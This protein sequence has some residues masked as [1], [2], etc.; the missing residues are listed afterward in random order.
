ML[1]EIL[2]SCLTHALHSNP[3]LVYSLLYQREVFNP[4]ATT[5]VFKDLIQNIKTVSGR[6]VLQWCIN[7][8]REH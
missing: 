1:L 5:P 8:D 3:H 4:L 7:V 6:G 2:N